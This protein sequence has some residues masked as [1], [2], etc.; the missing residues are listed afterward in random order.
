MKL[1]P[2]HLAEANAYVAEYH[3][4]SAPVLSARFSVGAEKDGELVGVVLVGRPVARALQDGWTAEVLRLATDG[5]RNACSMLYGAAWRGAQALGYLRLVT[6]TLDEEGGAS[7]RASGWRQVAE[8]DARVG[9]SRPSRPRDNSKY[10]SAS[11]I[12]WE[13]GDSSAPSGPPPEPVIST[14]ADQQ[15]EMDAA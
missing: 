8:L 5:T 6:Y 13:K 1:C 7:L 4:H 3:R 10:L 14:T 9:W 15:L 2:V 12:R 11:R